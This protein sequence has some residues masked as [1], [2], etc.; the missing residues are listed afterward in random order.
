MSNMLLVTQGTRGDVS[1]FVG[2]GRG[3]RARGHTV[4]LFSNCCYAGLAERAG[5]GFV[6][7]DTPAQLEAMIADRPLMHTPH[8]LNQFLKQHVLPNTTAH[9]QA[10][11]ALHQPGDT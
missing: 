3:L 7:L 9:Y 2:L 6:A 8:G 5:L 11:R 4:T 1:P 10:I